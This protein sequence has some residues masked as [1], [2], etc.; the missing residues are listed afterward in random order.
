MSS[1]EVPTSIAT[2]TSLPGATSTSTTPQGSSS[3]GSNLYLITFL[4][5]LLVLLIVSTSIVLRSYVVRRRFRARVH[6]ARAAGEIL[7]P[8]RQ[9]SKRRRFGVKP[10]LYDAWLTD[11][12][13]TWDEMMPVSA[14]TVKKLSPDEEQSPDSK[15][16]TSTGDLEQSN[17]RWPILSSLEKWRHRPGRS[18]RPLSPSPL[19]SQD[20]TESS[21]TVLQ[22]SVLV[23]MPSPR[24]PKNASTSSLDHTE[25]EVPDVL[26]GVTRL[27]YKSEDQDQ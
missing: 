20:P 8:P 16:A 1:A 10:K 5:T 6:A 26:F 2:A 17:S 11:G 13:Y 23:A 19:H 18:S 21:P 4:A 25:D 7:T 27:P 3:S 24:R 12:G 14:L 15:E 9:G 22:V